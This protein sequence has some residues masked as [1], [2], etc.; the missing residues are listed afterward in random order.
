MAKERKSGTQEKSEARLY[1]DPVSFE[2]PLNEAIEDCTKVLSREQKK[3]AGAEA[4]LRQALD[5][6]Q[7]LEDFQAAVEDHLRAGTFTDLPPVRTWHR[8]MKGF[9][10]LNCGPF[11]GVFL[12]NREE[13]QIIALAFSRKPHDLSKRL[14]ELAVPYLEE[15]EETDDD[16]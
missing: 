12:V 8:P 2:A 1:R 3:V 16:K 11:R 13:D 5:D 7:A 4:R 10:Q 6:H 15:P 14:K 9:H